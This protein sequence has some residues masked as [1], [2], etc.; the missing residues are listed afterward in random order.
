MQLKKEFCHIKMKD[1]ETMSSYVARIKVT[2]TNLK[3]AGAE[4]KDEDL[5]YAIL[6]GYIRKS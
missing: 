4:T 1:G 3:Q 2:V 5:A 6:A